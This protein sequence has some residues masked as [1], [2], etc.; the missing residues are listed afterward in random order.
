MKIQLNNIIIG[1]KI[2]ILVINNFCQFLEFFKYI[3][4]YF[5]IEK[6]KISNPNPNRG[7]LGTI[8]PH[9]A[10]RAAAARGTHPLSLCAGPTR[11]HL[12]PRALAHQGRAAATAVRTRRHAPEPPRARCTVPEP[13]ALAAVRPLSLWSINAIVSSS[14]TL[15]PL[16]PL[17]LM[18]D[19]ITP[20]T[21]GVSPSLYKYRHHHGAFSLPTRAR[22]LSH[23]PRPRCRRSSPRR[24]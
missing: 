12:L 19:G 23:S 21:L 9:R 7:P 13:P 24:R 18:A 4:L 8:K 20:S 5:E 22:P 6:K 1:P 17:P 15:S 14:P 11:G 10:L 16:M 3:Y 2:N